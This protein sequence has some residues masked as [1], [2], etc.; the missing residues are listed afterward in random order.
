M[1]EVR[2]KD[3]ETAD[4]LVRR[5]TR[6][7]QQG[8]VLTKARQNRFFSKKKNKRQLRQ[9]ANYRARMKRAVDKL[10]K[11]GLFEEDKMKDL[12]RKI[13]D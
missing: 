13:K 3:R 2:Q 5:F 6:N 7:I 4:S 12:K 11:M 1:V 9:D 8:K 10:K